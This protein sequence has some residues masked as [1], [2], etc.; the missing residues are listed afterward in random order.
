MAGDLVVEVNI[1]KINNHTRVEAGGCGAR[2]ER[3][4]SDKRERLNDQ[5]N[6]PHGFDWVEDKEGGYN[7]YYKLL[8]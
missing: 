7:N 4:S 3:V 8:L 1:T 5:V 2:G 6:P